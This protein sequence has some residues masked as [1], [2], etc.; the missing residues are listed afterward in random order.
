MVNFW[1]IWWSRCKFL[2][3]DLQG[4]KLFLLPCFPW[5]F[6][7]HERG[8]R[9]LGQCQQ[10]RCP[11]ESREERSWGPGCLDN[12][13]LQGHPKIK[14]SAAQSCLTLC[15]PTDSSLPV[16]SVHGILQARVLEWVAMS[17]S[18]G[19]SQPRDRT[20]VSC[21]EGSSLYHLSHQES[22]SSPAATLA[23]LE[24]PASLSWETH[25]SFLP[26]RPVLL[27]FDCTQWINTYRENRIPRSVCSWW[28]A[29]KWAEMYLQ[30]HPWLLGHY[31]E[32]EEG[33][34]GLGVGGTGRLE[35]L[36]SSSSQPWGL[37]REGL[38]HQ[39]SI[40]EHL[41]LH[42]PSCPLYRQFP[43]HSRQDENLCS[44]FLPPRPLV[45][46]QSLWRLRPRGGTSQVEK[47]CRS[48]ILLLESLHPQP[49]LDSQSW[50]SW[51]WVPHIFFPFDPKMH[52]Y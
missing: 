31:C 7:N 43:S 23:A 8:L 19:S 25:T 44:W 34:A 45:W 48:I 33:R 28:C 46:G 16:S 3:F 51:P 14:V 6:P 36:P 5:L 21:L 47:E 22:P 37:T 32:L 1:L 27:G 18:R 49:G 30:C 39:V 2:N 41:S 29:L 17:F 50:D 42:F 40:W 24:L 15:D 4:K 35:M 13:V 10:E 20:R 9:F 12:L 11:R 52:I 26:V 38:G